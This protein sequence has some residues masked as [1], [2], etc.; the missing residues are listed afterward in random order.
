MSSSASDSDVARGKN[1]PGHDRNG[2]IRASLYLNIATLSRNHQ[3]TARIDGEG[4][5][6]FTLDSSMCKACHEDG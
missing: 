2:V 3:I 1:Y 6:E 4:F 5:R